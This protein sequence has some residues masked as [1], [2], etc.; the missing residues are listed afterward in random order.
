MAS[1]NSGSAKQILALNHAYDQALATNIQSKL[2][3]QTEKR[4]SY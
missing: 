4:I 3:M 2:N 1:D